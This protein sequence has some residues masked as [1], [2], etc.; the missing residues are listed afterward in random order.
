VVN[1]AWQNGTLKHPVCEN[2]HGD[3]PI[4]K[5]ED[6]T[7]LILPGVARVLFN[8]KGLLRSFSD[9][10]GLHVN[11]AKSFLV[12]INMDQNRATHLANTFGCQVG[13]MPFTYLGLPLGTTKPNITE[14]AP[15]ITKIERRPAGVSKSSLIMVGSFV[16][17]LYSQPY[18]PFICVA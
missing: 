5:Y 1:K 17:T 9:S 8:L 2:F 11:F 18:L 10:T 12:P 16:L 4:V 3:Y 14:F 15:L 7:L 13:S 6:D